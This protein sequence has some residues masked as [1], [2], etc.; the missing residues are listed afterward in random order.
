MSSSPQD[1]RRSEAESKRE[2]IKVESSTE[3]ES[4]TPLPSPVRKLSDD[5]VGAA[6]VAASSRLGATAVDAAVASTSSKAETPDTRTDISANL[7][8]PPPSVSARSPVSSLDKAQLLMAEARRLR[9]RRRRAQAVAAAAAEAAAAASNAA[10]SETAS[11]V[12]SASGKCAGATNDDAAREAPPTQPPPPDVETEDEE[13]EE[14]EADREELEELMRELE[15]LEEWRRVRCTMGTVWPKRFDDNEDPEEDHN[16]MQYVA[17]LGLRTKRAADDARWDMR[18]R[19]KRLRREA[20]LS[21]ILVEEDKFDE[22]KKGGPLW[23]DVSLSLLESELRGGMDLTN[24]ISPVAPAD[25]ARVKRMGSES[26]MEGLGLRPKRRRPPAYPQPSQT[27]ANNAT[28]S[29]GD[30]Q[31]VSQQQ[32]H[33]PSSALIA[34]DP[35]SSSRLPASSNGGDAPSSASS[36]IVSLDADSPVDPTAATAAAPKTAAGSASGGGVV[37]AAASTGS[38]RGVAKTLFATSTRRDEKMNEFAREFHQ[39]VLQTTRQQLGQQ[40]SVSAAAAI[41]LPESPSSSQ[42]RGDVA[43]AV[44]PNGDDRA[45]TTNAADLFFPEHPPLNENWRAFFDS[46]TN[47][48]KGVRLESAEN[49]AAKATEEEERVDKLAATLKEKIRDTLIIKGC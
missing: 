23:D 14:G 27:E 29:P 48:I 33:H 24:G 46:F 15:E 28:P 31:E 4:L 5:S 45:T 8:S 43:S 42:E 9:K 41:V 30:Q 1:V 10:S 21:P 25:L 37:D 44:D 38:G 17:A 11:T 3:D 12:A 40:R 19:S 35:T 39:S 16:K 32:Q 18:I 47:Y 49:I 22:T 26:F 2:S 7:K 20:S 36:E 34:G 6:S 13:E